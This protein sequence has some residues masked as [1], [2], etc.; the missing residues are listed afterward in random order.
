[1]ARARNHNA[2]RL[3]IVALMATAACLCIMPVRRAAAQAGEYQV[4]AAYLY[5]F[6]NFVAWPGHAF[7]TPDSPYEICIL[8]A[9]PFGADL[10]NTVRGKQVRGRPVHVQRL[11]TP[12]SAR[13]CQILFIAASERTRL[14][15]ILEAVA[16]LPLLTVSELRDFEEHGGMV[17]F[18]VEHD[19][20]R[21]RINPDSSAAVGVQI[22]SKLLSVSTVVRGRGGS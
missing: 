17:R 22:S 20:V 3:R 14:P 19:T 16:G 5:Q 4:K 13:H 7:Q 18:V 8:G 21:L 15:W 11:G 1:M 10:D 9:D 12:A 2:R 6:L